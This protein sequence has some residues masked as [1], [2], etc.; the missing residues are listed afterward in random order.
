MILSDAI[1][2]YGADATRLTLADAGSGPDDANFDEKL[3]NSSVLK[4]YTEKIWCFEMIDLINAKA[5]NY[6]IDVTEYSPD[7][8][9]YYQIEVAM[10]ESEKQYEKMQ[11]Q[12]V[13]ASGF[14][15]FLSIRDVYKTRCQ[16]LN[17]A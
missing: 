17:I 11:Y 8:A 16:K 7:S 10:M 9:F 6:E 2:K 12:K 5:D 3:A 4:L 13:T 15:R 1:Q 14:Y